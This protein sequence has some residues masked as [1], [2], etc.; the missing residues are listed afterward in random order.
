MSCSAEPKSPDLRSICSNGY[1]VLAKQAFTVVSTLFSIKITV[2]G[3]ELLLVRCEGLATARRCK[4]LAP[5]SRG[6]GVWPQKMAAQ[7]LLVAREHSKS[8]AEVTQKS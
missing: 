4:T 2:F 7:R 5:I 8:R 6:K 1:E 3:R